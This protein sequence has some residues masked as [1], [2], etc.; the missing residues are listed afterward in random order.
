MSGVELLLPEGTDWNDI[1][2]SVREQATR[3]I[4]QHGALRVDTLM[5]A[6][7]CR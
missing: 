1:T 4:E 5:G 7:L 6:F 2:A 3:I